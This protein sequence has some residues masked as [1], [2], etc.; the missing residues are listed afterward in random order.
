MAVPNCEVSKPRRIKA[1][2]SS[3]LKGVS[4]EEKKQSENKEV[5]SEPTEGDDADGFADGF[6]VVDEISSE[7]S[8]TVQPLNQEL[9]FNRVE[10][11]SISSWFA[12]PDEVSPLRCA[13]YGWEN[14][15]VDSLKC[16]SCKEVLYGGLP[17]KWETDSYEKACKKLEESLKAGHSKIC[18]WQ[19]NPS[20]AS[21]LEVNLVSTQKAVDDFL[22][23]VASIRCFGTSIPAVDLSCLQQVEENEDVLS[24]LVTG[25]LGEEPTSDYKERIE[26]VCFMALSGWSRSSPEV[27]QSP[28]MS[29][30]FC[31]RN[32]G[33]W[34]FTPFEQNAKTTNEDESEPTAKRLKVDKGL[35]NPIEE[36]RS[37]CPWTKPAS[38][39]YTV[40]SLPPQDKNQDDNTPVRP[41]WHGL[42]VLLHERSS[43]NKQGPLTNKQ[44]TPPSQAWKAVRRITNFWQSR[45]AAHKT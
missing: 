8:S 26:L 11:F 34:N 40:R 30:E 31:R 35:F 17:P 10:T 4:R 13:Q 33:L 6:V 32:V 41:A 14:I 24:R 28:T 20:P 2:L 1:L 7:Q 39:T 21:F 23:R 42:Q 45:S 12:K 43:P 25:V 29:C 15:D 18:P 44:V 36:H 3:F 19:S 5:I 22:H 27:S 16:V 37:W 9:F 38:V